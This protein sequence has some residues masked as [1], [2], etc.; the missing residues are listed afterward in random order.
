MV[1]LIWFSLRLILDV[2]FFL[3]KEKHTTLNSLDFQYL[4]VS[5]KY[6]NQQVSTKKSMI[7]NKT[8]T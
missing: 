1:T 5:N 6:R 8:L 3:E 7:K 4:N 2:I